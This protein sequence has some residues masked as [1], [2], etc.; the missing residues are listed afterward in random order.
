MIPPRIVPSKPHVL[1]KASPGR[2]W[3]PLP[4]LCG[5]RGDPGSYLRYLSVPA[6]SLARRLPPETLA[7]VSG[8]AITYMPRAWNTALAGPRHPHDGLGSDLVRHG[9]G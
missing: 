7:A 2:K 9:I 8:G 3:P 4:I 1:R 5:S 6:P